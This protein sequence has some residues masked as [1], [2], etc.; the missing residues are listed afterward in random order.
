MRVEFPKRIQKGAVNKNQSQIR[1]GDNSEWYLDTTYHIYGNYF[2][3]PID[4]SGNNGVSSH[5]F[6]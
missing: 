5:E 4:H 1:I 2:E 6:S 3:G